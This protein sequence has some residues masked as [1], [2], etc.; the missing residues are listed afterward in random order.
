M[1]FGRDDENRVIASD[2]AVGVGFTSTP[3]LSNNLLAFE[4]QIPFNVTNT[5]AT[6]AM[7][8]AFKK[9][10]P[11]LIGS[12]NYNGEVDEAWASGLLLAAAV[13]KG[14]PGNTITSA[15]ILKGLH[16]LNGDTLGGMSPPLNYKAG[17]P[18]LVDCWFWM[19]TS[20]NKFAEKYGLKPACVS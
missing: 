3:G 2:G 5:P 4:P 6:K 16:S 12:A 7:I 13:E 9:Y 15:E 8:S 10:S 20:G 17:K 1:R 18:N 19:T 11:G 14:N